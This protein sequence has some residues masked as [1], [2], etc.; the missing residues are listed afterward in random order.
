[1]QVDYSYMEIAEMGKT[2]S[3]HNLV[4]FKAT[5]RD[6]ENSYPDTLIA[7]YR[8]GKV[9]WVPIKEPRSEEEQNNLVLYF[10]GSSLLRN[11]MVQHM[12]TGSTGSQVFLARPAVNV[13]ILTVL[14]TPIAKLPLS[15]RQ[16]IA[17][18]AAQEWEI[19]RSLPITSWAALF[20]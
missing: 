8:E 10:A 20:Y 17:T 12:P 16:D 4:Y 5:L 11:E 9:Q 13:S 7:I 2:W 15:A 3:P 6:I 19:E 1:M 18:R 14:H